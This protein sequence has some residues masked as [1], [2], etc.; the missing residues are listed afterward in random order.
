[1][2]SKQQI[3]PVK[4]PIPRKIFGESRIQGNA[5]AGVNRGIY[6]TSVKLPSSTGDY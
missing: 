4:M 2:L 1:L 5:I 3:K 6:D